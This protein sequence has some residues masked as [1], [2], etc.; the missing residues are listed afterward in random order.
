MRWSDFLNVE[1][2]G[3][4]CGVFVVIWTARRVASRF[5][6]KWFKHVKKVAWKLAPAANV[7][8]GVG[9]AYFFFADDSTPMRVAKGLIAGFASQWGRKMIKRL[10]LEKLGIDVDFD[11]DTPLPVAVVGR[12]GR[13]QPPPPPPTSGGEI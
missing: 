13:A 8:L 2:A 7:L 9:G 1:M 3:L 12:A 5:Q 10:V 4:T 11:G 6:A